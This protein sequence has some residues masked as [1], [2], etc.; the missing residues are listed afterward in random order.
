M[1]Q[2]SLKKFIRDDISKMDSY[3]TVPSLWELE[4]N[5]LKLN[6]GENPYGFSPKINKALGNFKYYNYYPDPEYKSLRQALANYAGVTMKKIMVGTGS[7]ELLDLFLRLIL[8][9]GDKVINCPPTFGMYTALIE[10]NKGVVVSVPRKSDFSLDIK[11]I[12][13]KID[14]K[15]KL[16]IICNPNNPTGSVSKD[17]E[18]VELLDT[19][20]LVLV[21]EAYF[22][23]YGKTVVSLLKKYPNLIITR[24][25]SKWAGIAGLRLGFSISS[26]FFVDQL[27]KIKPPFNV[28]LAAEIAGKAALEDL[29]KTKLILKKTIKERERVYTQ[30][31]E[32]PYLKIYP[33]YANLLYMEVNQNFDQLKDYLAKNKIIVRL[34]E[35]AIRLT[36]GTPEQNSKVIQIFKEFKYEKIKKYA[37]LDRDG[38]LIFEPQDTFQIDSIKKLKLLDGVIK[39]LKELTEEEYE[40]IMISNQDG[41]GTSSFPRADFEI[42]QNK[43]L[44]IFEKNGIK[45]KKIFICSHLPSENCDCRKPKIGLVKKFLINNKVD[46]SKSFVCGDR[47]TDS[48]FAKNIG[49]KFIPMQTNGNFYTA[50]RKGEV[51]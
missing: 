36:I 5:F 9:E 35:N 27:L 22:E 20:K 47:E 39:G 31:K 44:S 28:N 34:S 30:L 19:G 2:L 4:G 25:L 32:I 43:M 29:D 12:K 23:F 50:L 3:R 15:V 1:K 13:S 18:I 48:L 10:L 6:A 33:S 8:D 11:E 49:I 41:L 14:K 45:F 7:D 37:F 40:L 46:K 17:G 16:I 21:D 38:T 51:I 24:T 26:P 42:P